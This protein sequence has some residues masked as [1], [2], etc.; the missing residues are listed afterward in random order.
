MKDKRTR[1]VARTVALQS[2]PNKTNRNE[3]V[4]GC[5]FLPFS[6]FTGVPSRLFRVSIRLPA[7]V[8]YPSSSSAEKPLPF[9]E[10]RLQMRRA[11]AGGGGGGNPTA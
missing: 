3:V 4:P 6:F 7:F 5:S 2:P 1:D 10:R 9:R 11:G 8:A